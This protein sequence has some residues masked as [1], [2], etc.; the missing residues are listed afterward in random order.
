MVAWALTFLA[1][2]MIAGIFGFGG[3]VAASAGIAQVVF[4]I[5]LI[6]FATSLIA[7]LLRRPE[8]Y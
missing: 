5:F 6:L 3:I 1:I 2:G 7:G 4:V 8:P